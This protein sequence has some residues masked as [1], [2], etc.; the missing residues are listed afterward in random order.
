MNKVFQNFKKYQETEE[1][2]TDASIVNMQNRVC[3]L[4]EEA[5][6]KKVHLAKK[7]GIT[8]QLLNNF[9]NKGHNATLRTVGKIAHGLNKKIVISFVDKD[10]NNK[11]FYNYVQSYKLKSKN[12]ESES[13]RKIFK[14]IV[15]ENSSVFI[16]YKI[17]EDQLYKK[18]SQN[19]VTIPLE[20]ELEL[21]SPKNFK[22][23]LNRFNVSEKPQA[24]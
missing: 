10:V 13:F 4:L 6:L 18:P 3:D 12:N 2:Y 20:N 24:S 11:D 19:W 22:T 17:K 16:E 8:K 15:E 9:F 5:Q 21:Y 14:K 1:S 7:V 23:G